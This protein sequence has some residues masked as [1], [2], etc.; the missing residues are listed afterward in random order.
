MIDTEETKILIKNI[1]SMKKKLFGMIVVAVVAIVAGYNV[2]LSQN[3]TKLSDL[4]LANVEAL[5]DPGEG[6][7]QPDVNDCISDDEHICE[8][9]HPTDP[10]KDERRPNAMWP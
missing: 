6:S 10:S 3:E 5:A 4:V 1:R 2:Y 9:L 7:G 8:A